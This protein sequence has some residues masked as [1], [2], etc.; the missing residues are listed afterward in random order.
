MYSYCRVGEVLVVIL[1]EGR[2]RVDIFAYTHSYIE[3]V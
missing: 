3:D 1:V 2:N